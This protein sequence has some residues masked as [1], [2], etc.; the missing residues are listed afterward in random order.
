MARVKRNMFTQGLSGSVG[1]NMVF[2]NRGDETIVA[3]SPEHSGVVTEKQEE[4][5]ETFLMATIFA[6]NI[7]KDE[8]KRKLYQEKAD[9]TPSRNSYLVAVSD[10]LN[11]PRIK[12]INLNEYTGATGSKMKARVIDDFK[13]ETVSFE[14]YSHE[15]TL[16]EQGDAIIDE[17]GLSWIYTATQDNPQVSGSKIVVKATDI[18]GNLTQTEEILN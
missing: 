3:V 5:R 15:G 12:N 11:A 2:R 7:L 18:P 10:F 13:V 16:I 9:T 4:V 6:K 14:I 1:S 17:T 8:T